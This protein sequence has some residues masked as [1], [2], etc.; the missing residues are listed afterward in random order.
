MC[1]WDVMVRRKATYNLGAAG[2]GP[3]SLNQAAASSRV[4]S[5]RCKLPTT[6]TTYW[7]PPLTICLRP[8]AREPGRHLLARGFQLLAECQQQEQQP[9]TSKLVVAPEAL[10][11][12]DTS[13]VWSL[14]AALPWSDRP[15]QDTNNRRS[16]SA[17]A[18]APVNQAATSS[19]VAASR[20]SSGE[21]FRRALGSHT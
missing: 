18:P 10:G 21:C 14:Q 9:A 13:G 11:L 16:P 15:R 20:V 6:S 2:S 3:A 7:Q 8:C 17:G 19:L 4:P 5:N 12:A 1:R